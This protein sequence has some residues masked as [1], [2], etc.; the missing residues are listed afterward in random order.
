MT[1]L[2][3]LPICSETGAPEIWKFTNPSLGV[4]RPEQSARGQR[5]QEVSAL[6][7]RQRLWSLTAS[8]L[9]RPL[10][11]PARLG[12]GGCAP[13]AGQS[14]TRGRPTAP[15]PQASANTGRVSSPGMPCSCQVTVMH[16]E[17]RV[18]L[19]LTSSL[20]WAETK[21]NS[22]DAH[23][24]HLRPHPLPLCARCG[25]GPVLSAL[26][27]TGLHTVVV[28]LCVQSTWNHK[29]NHPLTHTFYLLTNVTLGVGG[30]DDF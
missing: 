14:N 16:T 23:S 26:R 9:L 12:V 28:D 7:R 2:C 8:S 20:I 3:P 10:P 21:K 29:R 24:R 27:S 15:G 22:C 1:F 19:A 13:S 30:T 17:T 4:G 11:G 25:F 18:C 5:G 6:T